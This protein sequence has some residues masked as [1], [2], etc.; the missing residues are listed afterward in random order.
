VTDEATRSEVR[1]VEFQ[2]IIRG[3]RWT[4]Q[5]LTRAT[6]KDTKISLFYKELLGG[7]LQMEEGRLARASA[8]TKTFHAQLER[9]EITDGIMYRRWWDDEETEKGR[10]IVLHVQYRKEAMKSAHASN[11]GRHM[12]VKKTQDKVAMMAY[13][14]GWQRDVREYCLKCDACARYHRGG[15]KKRGEL[16]FMCVGAPWERLAIDITGPHPLSGKGN[17]FIITVIDHFT[18]YAFAFPVRNLE[19]KTVAKYLV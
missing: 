2:K 4:R 18:K 8:I 15:V 10:Q 1:V 19:A 5:E 7:S 17:R 3:T 16:Q 14:V 12:G 11:S 13:W 9:S 6:E